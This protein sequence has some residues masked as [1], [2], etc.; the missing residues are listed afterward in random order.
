MRRHWYLLVAVAA[1]GCS[2]GQDLHYNPTPQI[3]PQNIRRLALHPI[4]LKSEQVMLG[5]KLMLDVRDAFL[6]DGR[7]PLVPEEQAD[8]VLWITVARYLNTPIQF[9]NT[10]VPISYKLDIIVDLQF[11]DRK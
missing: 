1:M 7:Y 9:D 2:A 4:I 6:T 11:V 3:L 10:L 8:G 5:D